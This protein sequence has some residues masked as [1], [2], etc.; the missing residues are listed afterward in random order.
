M[1]ITFIPNLH[2]I[3]ESLLWLMNQNKEKGVNMYNILKSLFHAD[4]YHLNNY[5]RPVTGDT[6]RAMDYGTVPQNA[7]DIL[8]L[9]EL[10]MCEL[11]LDEMPFRKEKGHLYVAKREC[12]MELLSQSDIEALKEGYLEYGAL[13]FE[14]V[15][16]KN[17][18]HIAYRKARALGNN[19]EVLYENLIDDPDILNDLKENSRDIKF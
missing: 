14:E 11:E 7:Y 2:K 12:N 4:C 8:K 6:Y 17:H 16:R 19:T 13:N 15:K 10:M 18:E 5:A 3:L 9:E 1:K